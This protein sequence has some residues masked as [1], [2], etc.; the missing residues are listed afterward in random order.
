MTGDFAVFG[1]IR[2][3]LFSTIVSLAGVNVTLPSARTSGM[4]GRMGEY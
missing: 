2:L 1:T 4:M 3:L